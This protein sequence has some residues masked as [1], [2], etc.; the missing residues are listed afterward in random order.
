MFSQGAVA[1][2]QDVEVVAKAVVNTILGG[3]SGG[4]GVLFVYKLMPNKRWSYL[5]SLNGT[6]AGMVIQCAGTL[7]SKH[8]QIFVFIF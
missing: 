5:M 7:T 6:L 8:E 2:S 3:S 1:S 4:L